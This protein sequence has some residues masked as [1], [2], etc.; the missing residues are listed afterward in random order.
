MARRALA[1]SSICADLCDRRQ[2]GPAVEAKE[3][4][5]KRS[6][7]VAMP[8]LVTLLNGLTAVIA[9]LAKAVREGALS[10]YDPTA[11]TAYAR[12]RARV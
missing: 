11:V 1:R 8:D 4:S 2:R 9:A 3:I 12:A 6:V 10:P 7:Q 5:M